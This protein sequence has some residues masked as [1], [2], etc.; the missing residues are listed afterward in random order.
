MKERYNRFRNQ[1]VIVGVI[2]ILASIPS[3][4]KVWTGRDELIE[5]KGVLSSSD[6]YVKVADNNNEGLNF[7]NKRKQNVIEL[8]FYLQQQPYNFRL[9]KP[10]EPNV[11][12][13]A[14]YN[15]INKKLRAA[16]T[17]TVFISVSEVGNEHPYI[18]ML[19]ADNEEILT[20]DDTHS[21]E[22]SSFMFLSIL[23][24]LFIAVP[25]IYKFLTD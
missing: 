4:I 22:Q 6:I 8:L 7:G 23:G 24:C 5:V 21:E 1:M 18:Y 3:L 15:L 14:K 9:A 20:Y 19:K 16:D 10:L 12:G 25:F 2:S 17:I 11:W 13:S